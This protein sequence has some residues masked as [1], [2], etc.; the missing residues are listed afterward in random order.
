MKPIYSLLIENLSQA[1]ILNL[2]DKFPESSKYDPPQLVQGYKV[3]MEHAKTV[4]YDMEA[5]A[6][7]VLDHLAEFPDY[8]TRLK[9]VESK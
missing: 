7:I 5:I 6:K 8:Y 4:N 3:E 1:D 2:F 9:K